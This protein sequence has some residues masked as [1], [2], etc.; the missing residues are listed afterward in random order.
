[1][2]NV[3]AGDR[4]RLTKAAEEFQECPEG[5]DNKASAIVRWRLDDFAPGALRMES[6]LRGCLYW[7]EQDVVILKR[8]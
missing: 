3:K 7:N 8:A 2:K 1:M 4:V 6:D 5:R